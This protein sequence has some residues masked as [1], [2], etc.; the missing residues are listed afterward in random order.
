MVRNRCLNHLKKQKLEGVK[1]DINN[2]NVVELQYL[3]QLDFIKKEEKSMEELLL[4]SFQIAVE[5][6]PLKMKQ[7]FT[8]CKIEGRG[9]KEVSKEMGISLKMVEKH[10]SKAKLQICGKLIKLYP[11][12]TLLVTLLVD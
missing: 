5:E 8:K 10:I 6:L 9:Q 11:T 2:L 12:L 1:I 3:Y 7:V 4:A